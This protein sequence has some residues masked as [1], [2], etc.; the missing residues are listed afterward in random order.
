M[1]TQTTISQYDQQAI[2]FLKSTGVK[3]KAE[4]LK[5]DKHFENDKEKRDIYLITLKRGTR[6]F[7]FNFGQSIKY[8][9][10]SI[11]MKNATKGET[12]FYKKDVPEV[13]MAFT[14]KLELDYIINKQRAAPTAYDVLAALQ[15]YDVGTEDDFIKEF[16]YDSDVDTYKIGLKIYPAVVSEY[17][18]VCK[19]WTDKEIEQL[20]EIQ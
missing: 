10:K 16:G 18:M 19:L 12:C 7:S 14:Y 8:H 15:K 20:Q 17:D 4:F 9:A 1:E 5:F 2:D 11:Y 13:K 6:S 3:F